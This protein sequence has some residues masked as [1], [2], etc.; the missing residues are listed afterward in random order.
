MPGSYILT[1]DCQDL[2]GNPAVQK[3]R[4][5]IVRDTTPPVI[6][7]KGS[8]TETIEVSRDGV[9]AD[10]GA[11]CVDSVDGD[12]TANLSVS[13]DSVDLS[14]PGNYVV[15]YR[16]NDLSGNEALEAKRTIVVQDTMPPELTL[17][18]SPEVYD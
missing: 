13:G 1:Y 3:R 2:S 7:L 18:G 5:V 11:T 17:N 6:T 9:Y 8:E 14:V 15:I 10:L 16:C 4:T 12:L